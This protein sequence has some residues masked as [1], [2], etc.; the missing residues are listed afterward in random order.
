MKKHPLPTWL[1]CLL[2]IALSIAGSWRFWVPITE[3]SGERYHLQLQRTYFS[4]N[5]LW[6]DFGMSDDFRLP[7]ADTD[8]RLLLSSAIGREY[9]IV[10]DYHAR[11]HGSDYYDVYALHGA[12]GTAYLTIGE[13]DAMRRGML[14]LRITLVV[15]LDAAVCGL[16]LWKDWQRRKAAEATAQE[17]TSHETE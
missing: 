5:T 7:S 14:P 3:A 11:R 8:S 2:L 4:G 17:A 10:A 6:L 9:H 16:I 13:T 15:L 12:D 1:G